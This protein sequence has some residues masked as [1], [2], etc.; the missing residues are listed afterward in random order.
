MKEVS[1]KKI[2]F[3]GI[4]FVLGVFLLALCY[5]LF[6]LP[7]DFVF[8][9]MSGLSILLNKLFGIDSTTFIYVSSIVLLII[10]FIFLGWDKTKNTIVGSL[11]YP[12]MITFSE[13]IAKMLLPHF[14]LEEQIITVVITA[15]L[16]GLSNGLIY[17]CGYT[18]GG[19]DVL[20]QLVNK[21]LKISES[22]S[23]IVINTILIM[24]SVLVFGVE[25][26]IYSFIIL[27]VA[28][29]VID[30]IMYGISDSKLFY[31][32]T[33]EPKK[34]TKAILEEF[35]SGYT[36]LPTKGGYSH[37]RGSLLM[38]VVSNKDYYE[39]K[40]R[41]LEIDPSAFFIIDDCYE[42]NGGVKR[43]NFPFINY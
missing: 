12:L 24:A 5:N 17:R 2:I 22:K 18:T 4:F 21:Y 39:F 32:F 6:L 16:Y 31:V 13:P 3:D 38:V 20:M 8:S 29:L 34:L 42:V 19:S 25:K 37:T 26:S 27:I 1:N 30:R 35:E 10:S 36:I 41:I 43:S 40:T 11:L 28:S 33:R 23:L 9:G 7:N 15:L 14:Q